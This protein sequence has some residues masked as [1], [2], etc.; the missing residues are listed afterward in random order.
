MTAQRFNLCN[1]AAGQEEFVEGYAWGLK[2]LGHSVSVLRA[3]VDG[4]RINIIFAAHGLIHRETYSQ[5]Q[6]VI[7]F[8]LEQIGGQ[9]RAA[10]RSGYFALMRNWPNW[11]Y[12]RK[13]IEVLAR[14]GVTD[15]SHVPIGYAP[16]QSCIAHQPKDI[17]VVFYGS[18][19]ARRLKVID[20]VRA[21]GLTVV[22][23][24]ATPW[25]RQTR[26][27]YLARTKLVLNLGYYEDVHI[28]EEARISF[29][30]ANRIPVVS[31][32]RADSVYEEDMLQ[33]I[34]TASAQDL[35]E[36][37]LRLCASSTQRTE[38]AERG[39]EIFRKRDWLTPLQAAIEKYA[40]EHPERS[41]AHKRDVPLP[42]RLNLGAG[43]RWRYDHFN[44]D[45]A[46]AGGPDLIAD[47]AQP[48]DFDKE[49]VTWRFGQAKL[50][51][52][53][54]DEIRAEYS[55]HRVANLQQ[56]MSNCLD[57]LKD[58]GI[59][60]I[61]VPY[62][63]SLRAWT[64]TD[65]VRAFNENSWLHFTDECWRMGWQKDKFE[66]VSCDYVPS[67]YGHSLIAAG[68][69]AASLRRTPRAVEALKLCLRKRAINA[70]EWDDY[71][72]YFRP[73]P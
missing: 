27:A 15:V 8:N 61:E 38:L 52:G 34:A 48:F 60:R 45:P 2:Q 18:L 55:L 6:R 71:A 54:F 39:L 11:D 70:P 62:D 35:P 7:N 68:Q 58:G 14:A 23:T 65:T 25:D 29:L 64:D 37:C 12:A 69:D 50:A 19:S 53:Y 56:C 36:L 63:L 26:D 30:L 47:P 43:V 40:H 1:L 46:A 21:T 66:L 31:E 13:N 59:M 4:A 33:C 41:R 44:L 10:V 5:A 72:Q 57:W 32:L 9:P 42:R 16:T 22:Y 51:K 73:A 3:T 24:H 67:D 20:A 17:D 28:L 49:Q